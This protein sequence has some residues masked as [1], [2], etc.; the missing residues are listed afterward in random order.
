MNDFLYYL[1][2]KTHAACYR[3]TADKAET[4][5]GFQSPEKYKGLLIAP[6]RKVKHDKIKEKW[7]DL[8]PV[9]VGV[10]SH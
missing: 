2:G 3:S 10:T 9:L 8:L 1:I 4:I 5:S 6:K 7:P